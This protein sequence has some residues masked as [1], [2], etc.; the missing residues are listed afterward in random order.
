[1]LQVGDEAP[2]FTLP[3]QHGG[4]TSLSDFQD[5]WL[6]VWWIPSTLVEQTKPCCDKVAKAFG[7]SFAEHP[8]LNV[9]GISFD[10]MDMMKTFAMRAL[11]AFPVLSDHT[12]QV[13][14][15]YGVR[16]GEGKDWDS[17]PLKRAF[18]VDPDGGI[19]KIYDSIDPD[20]FVAEVLDDLAV[21]RG[22]KPQYQQAVVPE[23]AGQTL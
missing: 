16:R 10:A 19:D 14:E 23:W 6:L 12:K 11:I 2:S 3:N 8:E 1:M 7:A 20:F 9:V 18:L 17:F 15:A 4:V 5:Q 13:G 21:R 22:L